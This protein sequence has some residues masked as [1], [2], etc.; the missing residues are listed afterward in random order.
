MKLAAVI[1]VRM[2]SK[3]L[4]GKPLV[5]YDGNGTANLECII[6]RVTTCRHNPA[7]IVA[8]STDHSD[9]EIEKWF[10]GYSGRS[11]LGFY[12]G[13]LENV[14]KRFNDALLENS[15]HSEYVWR[16]MADNPLVDVCLVS[17]RLDVL[18]RN[19][20]DV[21]MPILPEPTYAA[22]ANVWSRAAWDFCAQH[23]SG[24]QLEHPG[25]YLYENL[26]QFRVIAECGPESVYYQP[27]RTELDTL[28]DLEFFRRVWKNWNDVNWE[29]ASESVRSGSWA[30]PTTKE[31]LLWLS[32]RPDIVALNAHIEEKT[33]TTYLHGH[34]RA[35]RFKCAND[36]CGYTI[37]EK[38]NERLDVKCPRC[39][40]TRSF[41]P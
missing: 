15:A 35:R 14:T 37:A 34:H 29:F 31:T 11:N 3:R 41:Y 40:T 20:A 25:E 24:S 10:R 23:S 1:C 9:D 16:V 21:I 28:D 13:S 5:S 12:R 36:E 27:I 4:N 7:I 6:E 38:V 30:G 26:H 8:T 33:H 22:Q 17:W 39:G 32:T 2:S 18:Q 19:K